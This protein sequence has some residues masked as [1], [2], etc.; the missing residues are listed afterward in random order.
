MLKHISPL[1]QAYD[2]IVA[3]Y[4]EPIP[5]KIEDTPAETFD[6]YV[7]PTMT[8]LIQEEDVKMPVLEEAPIEEV[9]T[10]A[11]PVVETPVVAPV[12]IPTPIFTPNSVALSVSLDNA[13]AV[14]PVVVTKMSEQQILDAN[15]DVSDEFLKERQERLQLRESQLAE[16][17]VAPILVPQIPA[18]MLAEQKRKFEEEQKA[19]RD[20]RALNTTIKRGDLEQPIPQAND[21]TKPQ[22]LTKGATLTSSSDKKLLADMEQAP[23]TVPSRQL[24][25]LSVPM[26]RQLCVKKGIQIGKANG[27][28]PKLIALLKAAGVSSV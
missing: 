17:K 2:R 9:P 19:L 26:L 23:Q 8:P 28:K 21:N 22:L 13:F 12:P 1:P 24:E 15:P 20:M 18:D 6:I 7:P 27:A 10:E 3:I 11:S 25:N 14:K 4:T 16:V 5:E